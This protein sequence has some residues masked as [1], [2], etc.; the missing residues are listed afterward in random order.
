MLKAQQQ[1]TQV[2]KVTRSDVKLGQIEWLSMV[3]HY[4]FVTKWQG[5]W[6]FRSVLYWACHWAMPSGRTVGNSPGK[7][8]V[9]AALSRSR[10][11]SL[12]A[13]DC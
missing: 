10:G 5:H 11:S 8:P 9:S 12:C 4:L 13:Q 6:H 7:A 2:I 3:K 1:A